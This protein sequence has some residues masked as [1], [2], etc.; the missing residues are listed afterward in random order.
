[1]DGGET[2]MF[3]QYFSSW[4]ESEDSPYVGLGRVYPAETIAEWD[5]GSLHA[6]NRRRLARS[7][8]A[9]MGFMP[10]D[11]TGQKE[12]YRIENFELV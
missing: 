11:S 12:I 9:A 5:I 10:D 2:T 8:G 1:M 7:A 6:E 4:K 3:K